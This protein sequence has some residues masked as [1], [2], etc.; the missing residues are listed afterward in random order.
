MSLRAE[1]VRVSARWFIK[2]R[3]R[4][5]SI[6]QARE[7][8]RR[9]Q[10]L[11]PLPPRRATTVVVDA[12]GVGA[13][14]V[15]TPASRPDHHVLYLHG[16]G[17]VAGSAALYRHF[18]W[19]I[20]ASTRSTLLA[21]NYRLAPEHPFPAALTDAVAA[22]QWLLAQAADPKAIVIIGDSAGGGLTLATLMK[23]RDQRLPLPAAAVALSP[24]TDL[25]LTGASLRLNAKADSM[26][27]SEDMQSFADMYLA[28]TDPKDPYVSPL[29][30]T[31]AG[32]PPILILVGSE[33][34]L[35]D[36]AVRMAERLRNAG[37]IVELEIWPRMLHVWPLFV[38]VMP[39]AHRAIARM[40][41]FVLGSFDINPSSQASRGSPGKRE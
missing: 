23:L 20:A 1:L 9:T 26:L 18:T 37:G 8:L 7:R 4:H 25:A 28:G 5:K 22:Y 31:G 12:G 40:G 10:A 33:E 21:I 39:E 30:D 15:S 3:G 14:R 41:R 36:D 13:H 19:R 34:V 11:V 2:R 38:P 35:L 29:Y 24:W 16:G 17:Y 27:N 6:T 32:L